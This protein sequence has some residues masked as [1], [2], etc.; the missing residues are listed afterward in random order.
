MENERTSER[1]NGQWSPGQ[2]GAVTQAGGMSLGQPAAEIRRTGWR[3][4][5]DIL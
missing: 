4:A 2:A 5:E 1:W 3:A